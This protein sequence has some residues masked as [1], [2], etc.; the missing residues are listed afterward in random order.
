[1]TIT[2]PFLKA[3]F[4]DT[5]PP[6]VACFTYQPCGRLEDANVF[7]HEVKLVAITYLQSVFSFSRS[8]TT[9]RSF[10]RSSAAA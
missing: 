3:S 8:L 7:A 10:E 2:V 9:R 4:N 5:R 6:E 1:M